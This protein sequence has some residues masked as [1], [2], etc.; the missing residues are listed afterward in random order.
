MLFDKFGHAFHGLILPLHADVLQVF[1]PFHWQQLFFFGV[2]R[3][4]GW[5]EVA[6]C[7]FAASGDG[8]D[9]IHGEFAGRGRMM[10]PMATALGAASLPPLGGPEFPG[11]MTFGSDPSFVQMDGIWVYGFGFVHNFYWSI[12]L[13][14]EFSLSVVKSKVYWAFKVLLERV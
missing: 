9:V 1:L 11:F 6:L 8:D 4:T 10:A 5:N 13:G 3:F 14:A 2:A 12:F 7:A